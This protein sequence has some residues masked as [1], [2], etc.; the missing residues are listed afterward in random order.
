MYLH[1]RA[2]ECTS[3]EKWPIEIHF[4][5]WLQFKR[6]AEDI[7]FPLFCPRQ[8]QWNFTSPLLSSFKKKNLR[9]A[10]NFDQKFPKNSLPPPKTVILPTFFRK[11]LK[12]LLHFFVLTTAHSQF[13]FRRLPANNVVW[14]LSVRSA[15]I[16][17]DDRLIDRNRP[18]LST[19]F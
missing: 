9:I 6:I 2:S 4:A 7:G 8:N 19:R 16:E 17:K 10:S 14:L 11:L 12:S 13:W 15:S 3:R 18:I 1:Q 5:V